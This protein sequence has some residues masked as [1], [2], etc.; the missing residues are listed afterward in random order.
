VDE[1]IDG[2]LAE[3]RRLSAEPVGADELDDAKRSMVASFA[4]TLEEVAQVVSYI[5]SRRFY[6]LATDYW[7]RYPE[8]V[9]AVSAGD[10]QRVASQYL[11]LSKLQLVAVGDARQLEP[12]LSP[13]GALSV[14]K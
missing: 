7:E 10:V 9:M 8:K 3:L 12:L 2:F 6:G 5:A 14:V 13:L 1:G 4:L 11:D